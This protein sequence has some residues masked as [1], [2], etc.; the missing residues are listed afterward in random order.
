MDPSRWESGSE[1]HW[2]GLPG[3]GP[4][5][6][7]P[8]R[9]GLELSSGRDALRL[10]LSLGVKERGWRR[11]WVPDYFCQDVTAAMVRSD[12]ELVPYPDSPLRPQPDP[13]DAR[14]GEAILLVN[15]FGLRAPVHVPRRDGVDIV[16]DHSHDPSSPW[17]LESTAD[18]CV[19]SLRK[20]FPVPDGGAVWSPVGHPLPSQPPIEAQRRVAV[21]SKLQG[22]I[23]KAMYLEG[24]PVDKDAYRA[25]AIRGEGELAVPL[26]SGMS[27]VSRAIITAYAAAA[28]RAAREANRSIL[29]ARISELDWARLVQPAEG[30]GVPF[31]AV[32]VVDSPERREFVRQRLIAQRIYPSIL[33]PLEDAVVAPG[34]AALDLSRRLLSIHCDGRYAGHDMERV[35]EQVA[36]AGT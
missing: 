25:L 7:S 36:M 20:T 5:A 1:F 2:L 35:G 22:M 3:P 14:P 11:L 32:I 23:L 24:L 9:S 21:S 16:E 30:A 28:W 12:L 8:W 15:Y 10:T 29:S 33:W 6:T 27:D 31:S 13:P 17:A 26:V 34:R 4:A 18:F 19:A